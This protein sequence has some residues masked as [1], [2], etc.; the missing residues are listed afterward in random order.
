MYP[1]GRPQIELTAHGEGIE[2]KKISFALNDFG[3]TH[4]RFQE[5]GEISYFACDAYVHEGV[6]KFSLHTWNGEGKHVDL[7]DES[8]LTDG[9]I[10]EKDAEITIDDK[11]Y[12]FH[13]TLHYFM[14]SAWF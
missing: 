1:E 9:A 11:T 7:I 5:R 12:R 4:Y 10:I 8:D 13:Y 2:I 14:V 6:A 3:E